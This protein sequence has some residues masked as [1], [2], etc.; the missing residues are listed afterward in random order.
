MSLLYISGAARPFTLHPI[1]SATKRLGRSIPSRNPP[2]SAVRPRSSIGSVRAGRGV[3]RTADGSQMGRSVQA[4]RPMASNRPAPKD[5]DDVPS[6]PPGRR[7][8]LRRRGERNGI[9]DVRRCGLKARVDSR[10]AV[11]PDQDPQEMVNR[12]PPEPLQ[13]AKKGH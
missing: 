7:G 13:Y 12:H 1:E 3:S 4:T 10:D 6:P 11:H 2:T 9:W 8:S 5:A